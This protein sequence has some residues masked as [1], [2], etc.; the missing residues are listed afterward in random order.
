MAPALRAIQGGDGM[1]RSSLYDPN[2]FPNPETSGT[3]FFTYGLAWGIRSGLLPAAGYT[4][5]VMLAWQGLTNLALN[6]DGRVGY[7]Q[8]IGAGPAN[9]SPASTTDF[10]VG[11]FLL[12][13]SEIY[14]LSSNAPALRPWA[15]VDQTLYDRDGDG[16][17]PITLDA[18][19]TEIYK[20][21]AGSFTWW[22]STNQI[23]SGTVVQTNLALGRHVLAVKA[24]GTDGITYQDSITVT[25]T[26]PPVIPPP[27][28]KLRFNF[29]DSGNTT[30]D[31]L[32]GV[33]L[34]L[35]DWSGAAVDL[36]APLGSG[37]GGAGRALDFTS[38]GAQG[39]NGPI[40]STIGSSAIDFGTVNRF[41]VSLWLKPASTLLV[42]GYPRFFSLGT[43]G[44][45]DRGVLGSLQLLSNGNL[46]ATTAVQQF[47]NTGQ[48]ASAVDMPSGRWT[49]L[50]LTYDGAAL[51][52]YSGSE[53]NSVALVSSANLALGGVPLGNSW[54][55]FL[56]NRIAPQD[57]AFRG[58]LDDV[59]FYL[60]AAPLDYLESVR[61]E[62]MPPARID[63]ARNG[64]EML[65]RVNTRA[66]LTYVL[67]AAPS[68][69]A[70][71]SWTPVFTNPGTGGIITNSFP[72]TPAA[73]S[74]FRY[75]IQ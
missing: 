44:T 31:S 49:F 18:S 74:F 50:A 60:E 57:R 20:G 38:S 51:N 27:V 19:Q 2:Q 10:G 13:C 36:H 59:R 5:A 52:L 64:P 65:L 58:W 4:N 55:L 3:G 46:Q 17:E 54:T 73:R 22:E 37:V 1:W 56:G 9:P 41:T 14:L 28:P 30:T 47:V 16:Q 23:A 26:E 39:S 63:A 53:T 72:M 48:M 68:L 21:M 34:N 66:G 15:G 8:G 11:A 43:N 45:T 62:A 29:E 32:A 6:A 24:L 35:L 42:G 7:V 12:A 67:E 61:R 70:P 25:V 75:R 71:A 69:A 40:A 33:S